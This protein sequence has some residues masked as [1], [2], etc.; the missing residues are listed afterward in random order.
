MT[1]ATRHDRV[2]AF[3]LTLQ[4]DRIQIT[5]PCRKVWALLRHKAPFSSG[6]VHGLGIVACD[7]LEYLLSSPPMVIAVLT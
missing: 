7:G 1:W 3:S 4:L 5:I 2:E 6:T